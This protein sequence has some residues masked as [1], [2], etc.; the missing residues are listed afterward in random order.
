LNPTFSCVLKI[1]FLPDLCKIFFSVCYLST[2][3]QA[4][5]DNGAPMILPCFLI[6]SK[7]RKKASCDT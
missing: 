3:S 2:A 5:P 6:S 7:S 4:Q 1:P